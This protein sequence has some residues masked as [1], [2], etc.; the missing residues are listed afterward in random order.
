MTHPLISPPALSCYDCIF[1][2]HGRDRQAIIDNFNLNAGDDQDSDDD[3]GGGK[4]RGGGRGGR[5][6]GAAFTPSI[7]LLTTKACGTGG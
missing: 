6:M 2:L 7:L 5:G 1:E 4:G 3:D